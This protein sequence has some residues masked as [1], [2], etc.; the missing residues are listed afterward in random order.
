MKEAVIPFV[1]KEHR[2]AYDIATGGAYFSILNILSNQETG[3]RL[4]ESQEEETKRN[5]IWEWISKPML[6]E[7][8]WKLLAD[9]FEKRGIKESQLKNPDYVASKRE[10]IKDCF[11][12]AFKKRINSKGLILLSQKVGGVVRLNKMIYKGNTSFLH[13]TAAIYLGDADAKT[14][15]RIRAISDFLN[16][17]L[18]STLVFIQ[19]PHHGSQENSDESFKQTFNSSFYFYHDKSSARLMKNT[20]LFSDLSAAG[21]LLDVTDVD[22]EMIEHLVEIQ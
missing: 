17:H 11:D 2:V 22:P 1:P 15:K 14:K 21:V 12:N 8:D 18:I 10:D 7:D 5:T 3:I 13:G 20:V 4:I 9:W 6:N 19:I 16:R